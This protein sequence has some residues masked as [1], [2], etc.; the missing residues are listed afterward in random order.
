MASMWQDYAKLGKQSPR[1][2]ISYIKN[3][4]VPLNLHQKMIQPPHKK[5]GPNSSQI[6]TK[7][8]LIL[9][10]SKRL[11]QSTK[12]FFVPLQ[13]YHT[14]FLSPLNL[15]H[16]MVH[17]PTMCHMLARLPMENPLVNL[18]FLWRCDFCA[19]RGIW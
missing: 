1:P 5:L 12:N 14:N 3:V 11:W 13:V 9:L 16:E 7:C 15:G 10:I 6:I 19:F 18:T 4:F 2:L 17:P 8:S